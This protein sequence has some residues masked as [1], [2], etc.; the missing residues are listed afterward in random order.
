MDNVHGGESEEHGHGVEGVE[1][2]LV[3]GQRVGGVGAGGEFDEAEEDAELWGGGWL[4]RE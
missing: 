2:D 3:V 4:V 1:V